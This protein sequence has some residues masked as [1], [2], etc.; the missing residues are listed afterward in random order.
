MLDVTV[1]TPEKVIFEGKAKSIILPG[2]QGVFELL[3]YHKPLLSR[4]VSGK[5]LIDKSAFSIRRGIVGINHN[6]A[7]IIIEE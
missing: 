7:T 1:V 3:P 2:E 4:L 6:K 5:L